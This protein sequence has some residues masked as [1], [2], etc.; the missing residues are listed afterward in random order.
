VVQV[1]RVAAGPGVQG[2]AQEGRLAGAW[3]GRDE[4]SGVGARARAAS[5]P[6]LLSSLSPAGPTSST[7]TRATSIAVSTASVRAFSTVGTKGGRPGS[8]DGADR[9]PAQGAMVAVATST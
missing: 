6:L 2:A 7:G 3:R 8:K 5:F 1:G 9:A 4:A